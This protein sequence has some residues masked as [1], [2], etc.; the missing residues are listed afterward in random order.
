MD[1]KVDLLIFAAKPLK[2][3]KVTVGARS[4]VVQDVDQD[5]V[6]LWYEEEKRCEPCLYEVRQTKNKENRMDGKKERKNVNNKQAS[7]DD[8]LKSDDAPKKGAMAKKTP[9]QQSKAAQPKVAKPSSAPS[10]AVKQ[11]AAAQKQPGGGKGP[12][13]KV[14][15]RTMSEIPTTVKY[16]IEQ[17]K[18]NKA[19]AIVPLSVVA[20]DA[21]LEWEKNNQDRIKQF[22]TDAKVG[23]PK[24]IAVKM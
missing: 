18:D 21:I 11:V 10:K 19:L 13:Y 24:S 1:T 3:M 5:C 4:G 6:R 15:E 14:G 20:R 17:M 16:W 22:A 23:V 9:V 8:L 12:R 7:I 2:G